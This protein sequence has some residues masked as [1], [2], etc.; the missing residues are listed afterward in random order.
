MKTNLNFRGQAWVRPPTKCYVKDFILPHKYH[1][2]NFDPKFWNILAG[3]K[4]SQSPC[5]THTLK[6]SACV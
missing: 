1:V 4:F 5:N 3:F 2:Q 6:C